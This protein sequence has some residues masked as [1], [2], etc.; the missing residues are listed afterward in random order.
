MISLFGLEKQY[1]HIKKFINKDINEC[2]DSQTFILG[3]N[4]KK[5][6]NSLT[7]HFKSKHFISCA[8]GTEALFLALL[9]SGKLKR[10]DYV[11]VP[12][13]T[14][15]STAEIVTWLGCKPIFFDIDEYTFNSDIIHIKN[16][17]YNSKFRNKIKG[18]ISVD[19]FGNPVNYQ[20]ISS[21]CKKNDILFISDG[22]Q[23]LGAK[24]K[25][26]LTNNLV[27]FFCT[28]FFPTKPLGC[29]G[30]GGGLFVSSEKHYN[31]IL[32]LR[33]HGKSRD[34]YDYENIGLNSRLDEI[35]ASIL[36][37]KLKIFD[38]EI[39]NRNIIFQKYSRELSHKYK[40]QKI[41]NYSAIG[42]CSILVEGDGMRNKIKKYLEDCK[43]QCG[44]YYPNLICDTE[45]YKKYPK[46]GIKNAKKISQTIISIP[47][48]A[49]LNDKEVEYIV[50]A[51]KDF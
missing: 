51:L 2:L 32:S 43:I 39:K 24:I 33:S 37:N 5:F 21:F 48:H 30:D 38:Q 46:T 25:N 29:Y 15:A 47:C 27:E 41:E 10:G 35:Q 17:Y 28:S 6:E 40:F 14:F 8:N 19:I 20:M 49:Y 12:S 45:A 42:L 1:A 3:D 18:L 9:S 11:M 16:T 13:F 4:V 26:K 44:I 31:K 23:A 22:A 7:K 34:K 36:L 50:S